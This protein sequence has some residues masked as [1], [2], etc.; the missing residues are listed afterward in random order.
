MGPAWYIHPRMCGQG[1][2]ECLCRYERT[3][4]ASEEQGFYGNFACAGL[5]MENSNDNKGAIVL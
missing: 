4:D 1:R 2:S 3:I 5:N